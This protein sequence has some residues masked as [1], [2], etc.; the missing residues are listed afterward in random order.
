MTS[1]LRVLNDDAA[2]RGSDVTR[3]FSLANVHSELSDALGRCQ[4]AVYPDYANLIAAVAGLEVL[5]GAE[6]P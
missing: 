5:L 1:Y 2:V 3:W 6:M 4:G